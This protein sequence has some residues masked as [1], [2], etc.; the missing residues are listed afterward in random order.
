MFVLALVE[1]ATPV[2]VSAAEAPLC[3]LRTG[4]SATGTP[5]EIGSVVSKTGPADVSA[6]PRASKAYFDCVNANGGI[7][8]R[9]I[10]YTIV[11]DGGEPDRSAEVAAKLLM[12]QKVVGL[13]GNSSFVDCSVNGPL[14]DQRDVLM[15][16]S[17]GLFAGML[18]FKKRRG[19]Q[20]G[21]APESLGR[22]RT[23]EGVI[24]RQARRLHR[25]PDRLCRPMG[26]RRRCG[27]GQESRHAPRHRARKY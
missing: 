26:V 25:R 6:A 10:H 23:C 13:V 17:Y 27:L 7:N 12:E 15:I 16:A 19:A 9:P 11:D 22:R 20:R 21:S 14:Y 4:N 18:L 3:G 24:R 1:I 2:N 8:G 5:I